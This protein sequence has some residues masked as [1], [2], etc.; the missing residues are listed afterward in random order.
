MAH[1]DDD[2]GRDRDRFV[3]RADLDGYQEVPAI[4]TAAQ[5]RFRAVVDT[6]ANTITWKLSYDGARGRRRR[7]PTCISAR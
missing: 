1:D 2:R 3:V 5:G 4:S 6:K 7:R